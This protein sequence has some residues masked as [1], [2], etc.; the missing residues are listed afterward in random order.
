[1]TLF[2]AYDSE[3]RGRI[4]MLDQ[5]EAVSALLLK[6]YDADTMAVVLSDDNL[7]RFRKVSDALPSTLEEGADSQ[8]LARSAS[9]VGASH[10]NGND[11]LLDALLEM[12]E[13]TLS[14]DLLVVGEEANQMLTDLTLVGEAPATQVFPAE[15]F[16]GNPF[17]SDVASVWSQFSSYNFPETI[18]VAL[19]GRE[20]TLSG[21][22][23]SYVDLLGTKADAFVV[24]ASSFLQVDGEVS[25]VGPADRST[26]V[27][28]ASGGGAKVA[29]GSAIDAALADLAIVS[30]GDL[31]VSD[32]ALSA[33]SKV[34]MSSLR[35]LLLENV[36][37]H[38]SDEVRLEALRTLSVDNLRFTEEL[39][40]IHMRA[41]TLDLSN[42]NFPA[43]ASIRLESLKG[44]IDGKYP[45]FG[46]PNRGYGRVNFLENIRSGGQPLIDRSTFDLHGT[47]L[48]IGKIPGR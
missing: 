30:R 22:N 27:V 48:T 24:S 19:A 8:L 2:Y 34:Y 28:L 14:V 47:N 11:F 38:A 16:T 36:S 31:S 20:V 21:G 13:G 9:F 32:A 37:V 42:L 41:T 17:Y 35:D 4:L 29:S 12:G 39:R 26:R 40:A 45:T 18:P 15:S 7:L 25:F 23:Y 43:N 6:K 10:A 5:N 1:M 3:L 44:G 33:G 46:T